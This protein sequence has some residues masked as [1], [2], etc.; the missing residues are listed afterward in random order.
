V[1]RKIERRARGVD[2]DE[3]GPLK[4]DAASRCSVFRGKKMHVANARMRSPGGVLGL[5][6]CQVGG[7]RRCGHTEYV[8][9]LAW[10]VDDQQLSRR[11]VE[12]QRLRR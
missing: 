10:T 1:R 4:P 6:L 7:R 9:A 3:A 2:R 8:T 11:F 12:R 5:F